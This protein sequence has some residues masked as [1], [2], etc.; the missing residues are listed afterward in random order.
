MISVFRDLCTSS[1]KDTPS[2][3]GGHRRRRPFS[4][5]VAA[6]FHGPLPRRIRLGATARDVTRLAYRSD[7]K[8][9][10]RGKVSDG[11]WG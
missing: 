2:A 11:Q 1:R 10:G 4:L 7:G 8:R 6:H 3:G 9:P 5:G